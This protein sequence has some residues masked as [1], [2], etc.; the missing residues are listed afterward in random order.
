MTGA[1]FANAGFGLPDLGL[2]SLTEVVQ[3]AQR[4]ADAIRVPLIVDADTG[5]GN[6]LNVV[7][8]VR[9]LERAGAAAIQLED[10]VSPKR[11]GHFEGKEVVS[12]GEMVGK[13]LAAV[14]TRRDVSTL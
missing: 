2:L 8:S 5:Y 11:C 1:G 13:L 14:D 6:A 12:V 7:R 4:L 9:E 3:Q 10:Q